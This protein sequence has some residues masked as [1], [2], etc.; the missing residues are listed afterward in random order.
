MEPDLILRPHLLREADYARRVYHV[1]L[2]ANTALDDVLDPN[3]WIHNT[4]RLKPLQKIEILAHDGSW[5]AELMVRSVSR[6]SAKVSVIVHKVFEDV[7]AQTGDIG[8][9]IIKHQATRGWYAQNRTTKA[10]VVDGLP[11]RESVVAFL[12]G[13]LKKAA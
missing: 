13:P 8:D 1:V 11:D 4:S 5:Y 7:T 3:F 9:H 6:A 12:Q 2:E 10:I